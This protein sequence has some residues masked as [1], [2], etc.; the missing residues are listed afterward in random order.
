MIQKMK[1]RRY[2]GIGIVSDSLEEHRSINFFLEKEVSYRSFTSNANATKNNL[3]KEIEKSITSTSLNMVPPQSE[4]IYRTTNLLNKKN[5][6]VGD[7]TSE[8]MDEA[9]RLMESWSRSK[10]TPLGAELITKLLY[11][12]IEENKVGNPS[13]F[14]NSSMAESVCLYWRQISEQIC[15]TKTLQIAEEMK[16]IVGDDCMPYNNLIAILAKCRNKQAAMA[17]E[18][19]LHRMI[20]LQKE[21]VIDKFAIDELTYNSA[22]STWMHIA[23]EEKEA[24]ERAVAILNRMKGTY[25]IGD[26]L[27]K[28]NILSFSMA[29]NTL[30]RSEGSAAALQ[31]EDIIQD[32]IYFHANSWDHDDIIELKRL[33]YNVLDALD[34]LSINEPAAADRALNLLRFM[35]GVKGLDP[36]TKAFNDVISALAKQ[37]DKMYIKKIEGLIEEMINSDEDHSPE[38]DTFTYNSLIKAYSRHG[39]AQ[40]ADSILRRMEAQFDKGNTHVKPSSI[41]WNLVIESYARLRHDRNSTRDASAVMHRM[42]EYGK[43]HPDVQPDRIT[44]TSMLKALVQKAKRGDENAGKQSIQILDKMVNSYEQGN[45]FMKPDKIIFST[46]MNC[47][48]KC[49]GKDAGCEAL[50]LLNRMQTMHREGLKN[51]KPD[52]MTVNTALSA[53]ANSQSG[54]S[55]AQAEKLLQAMKSSNDSDLSPNVQTY[56]LVISA[57]AKSNSREAVEK[58][59]KLLLDMEII[60]GAK[61]NVVSYSTVLNAFAKSKDPASYKRAM[62]VLE[63]MD[64]GGIPPNAYCYAAAMECISQSKRRNTI[65]ANAKSLLHRMMDFHRNGRNSEGSY[66]AV[67][68]TAIK[69]IISSSERR[70]DMIA[71]DFLNLMKAMNQ[72]N[73]G[74]AM[75]NIR[76]YN[77]FIRACV[78]TKGNQEDKKVA[79]TTAFKALQ[80]LRECEGVSPD[81]YTYPAIFRAGEELLGRSHEDL[82]SLRSIFNLCCQDGL[83]DA[84][85]MKNMVNFLPRDFMTSLLRTKKDPAKVRLNDLPREW[86]SNIYNN[87]FVGRRIRK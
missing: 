86:K 27:V 22:I 39:K 48:A 37:R 31:A 14:F 78:F 41:T 55:G 75:I 15:P 69:A 11:R 16:A 66:T 85:V 20:H 24:G 40:S 45:K 34:H 57:W 5:Y 2:K 10:R 44:I 83:V 35:Q 42:V 18:G 60:K 29:I 17:V 87:K 33:F 58:C 73:K 68:N 3:Q 21:G 32:L 49:G 65:H 56:T 81:L 26:G 36:D 74:S 72:K 70:K 1:P 63:R 84:L 64:S 54:E 9:V 28:P 30:L 43:K 8:T 61:P 6:P 38:P 52:T 71:T 62:R 51:M 79:F 19:I 67:F 7:F 12:I 13:A 59:E 80:E 50:V 82:E 4:L 25:R 77:A 23:R 76:T 46:V 47:I 53:L